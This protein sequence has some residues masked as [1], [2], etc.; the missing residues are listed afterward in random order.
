MPRRAAKTPVC[1]AELRRISGPAS[2]HERANFS[3]NRTTALG[4][5]LGNPG[6]SA[7]IKPK[8][9]IHNLIHQ[10]EA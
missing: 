2:P 7:L 1:C 3:G 4:R 5:G 6:E 9:V 8:D 10:S